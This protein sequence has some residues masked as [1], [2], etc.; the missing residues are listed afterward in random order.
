MMIN[1]CLGPVVSSLKPLPSPPI[2]K[3]NKALDWI[4]YTTTGKL[5]LQGVNATIGQ[6]MNSEVV[7]NKFEFGALYNVHFNDLSGL[8]H[9]KKDE[10]DEDDYTEVELTLIV[11]NQTT[12]KLVYSQ[13]DLI[14]EGTELTYEDA[15]DL[16]LFITLG[17]EE[18]KKIDDDYLWICHGWDKKSQDP[19]NQFFSFIKFQIKN[20]CQ[21]VVKLLSFEQED[22]KIKVEIFLERLIG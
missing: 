20:E 13:M 2:T 3:T 21:E 4:S 8:M 10:E 12:G 18:F 6:E 22:K 15:K 11:V 19:Y 17:S 1:I 7:N 5:A 16:Q 14:P 9:Y